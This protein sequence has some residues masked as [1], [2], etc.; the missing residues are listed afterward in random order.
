MIKT[1]ELDGIIFDLDGT[2]WDSVPVILEA[3]NSVLMKKPQVKKLL[4][5]EELRGLMGLVLPEIGNRLF[6]YLKDRD[7]M[8]IM[9]ECCDVECDLIREKGGRLFERLEEALED[10]SRRYPLFIVSNC[11]SGYIEAFL[12][13]HKLQKYFKDFECAGNTSKNKGENIKLVMSRNNLKNPVY[14]GDAQV[15]CEASKVARIPFVY[16]AY[17]FG[18]VEDYNIKINSFE[19]LTKIL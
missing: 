8:E 5:E 1:N 2:L 13:Y 19:D 12:Y 18:S 9:E 4:K 17:G 6:P 7:R 3:W 14:V 11:Q 10:L 16:A 15:D